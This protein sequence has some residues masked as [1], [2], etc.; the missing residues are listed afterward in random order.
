MRANEV[1]SDPPPPQPISPLDL[2]H[3][4]LYQGA[5]HVFAEGMTANSMRKRNPHPFLLNSLVLILS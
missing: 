1:G 4:F 3:N 2:L 5:V